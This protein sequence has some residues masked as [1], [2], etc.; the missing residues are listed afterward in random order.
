MKD[1]LK[2]AIGVAVI[3]IL[4][5]LLPTKNQNSSKLGAIGEAYSATS[6]ASFPIAPNSFRLI[7]A[8]YGTLGSVVI[9][10]NTIGQIE[11]YDATTTVNGSVYGTT[12]L[13]K[14]GPSATTNTYTFDVAFSTGL[15]VVNPTGNLA[16]TT[17]TWK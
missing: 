5:I 15:L 8:G 10:T 14:F 3:V 7:K 12:T 1:T 6:T 13:A 4:S 2:I 17:I 9:T 11:L 16:S